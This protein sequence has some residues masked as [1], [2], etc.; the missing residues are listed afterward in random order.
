MPGFAVVTSIVEF[1]DS[2]TPPQFI[3]MVRCLD[4]PLYS[5]SRSSVNDLKACTLEELGG[6]SSP[7]KGRPSQDL[8]EYHRFMG[9]SGKMM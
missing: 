8:L 7:K 6:V 9:I 1:S 2:K 3:D 5:K 4:L